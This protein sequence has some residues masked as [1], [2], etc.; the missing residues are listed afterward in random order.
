MKNSSSIV[1]IIVLI[2]G[3][4]LVLTPAGMTS[5]NNVITLIKNGGTTPVATIDHSKDMSGGT[6]DTGKIFG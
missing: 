1:I 2:L 6:T 3:I 4:F 5:I